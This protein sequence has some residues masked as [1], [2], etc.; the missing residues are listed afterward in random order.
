MACFTDYYGRGWPGPGAPTVL[1]WTGPILLLTLLA[2]EAA[3]ARAMF[4]EMY[5]CP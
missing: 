4:I 2:A 1:Y 3:G 5:Y